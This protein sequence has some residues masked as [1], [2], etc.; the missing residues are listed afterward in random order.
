MTEEKLQ[1]IEVAARKARQALDKARR[2]FLELEDQRASLREAGDAIGLIQLN[3]AACSLELTLLATDA[4][5]RELDD[6]LRQA[7]IDYFKPLHLKAQ[8]AMSSLKEEETQ[9]AQ[10]IVSQTND[11]V[12]KLLQLRDKSIEIGMQHRELR[13]LSKKSGEAAPWSRPFAD[14]ALSVQLVSIRNTFQDRINLAM[15]FYSD[16]GVPNDR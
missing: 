13:E 9:L 16:K 14:P 2:E 7:E 5:S 1:K 3:Q 10:E 15:S 11:V 4:K 6:E 8:Q 12:E